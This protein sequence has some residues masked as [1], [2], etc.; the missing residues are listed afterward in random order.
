MLKILT[1]LCFLFNLQ[2]HIIAQN[3]QLEYEKDLEAY[4]QY[5]N[6][7]FGITL[8]P[9]EEMED[10]NKFY[11]LWSAKK[12][13]TKY[14]AVGGLCGPIFRS[15]NKNCILAFTALPYYDPEIERK[16]NNQT[17]LDIPTNHIIAEIEENLGIYESRKKRFNVKDAKFTFNDYVTTIIGKKPLTMFNADSIFIYDFP[18]ANSVYFYDK[19]LEKIRKDKYIY[20]T[21]ISIVKKD[22]ATMELKMFFTEDSVKM[23]NEYIEM[24]SHKIWYRN[25][26]EHRK[27][28]K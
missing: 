5:L 3:G 7:Q 1:L 11:V 23:K 4:S 26:F 2:A 14:T 17:L 16:R 24:L 27:E 13:I 25:D 20:C 18:I 10:L 21:G 12:D 9:L 6:T 15:K 22:R 19:F 28:C 8:D